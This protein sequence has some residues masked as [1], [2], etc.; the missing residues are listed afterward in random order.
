MRPHREDDK[1]NRP[2]ADRRNASGHRRPAPLSDQGREMA[3]LQATAGNAAVVQLLRGHGDVPVQRVPAAAPTTPVTG[4]PRA[5]PFQMHEFHLALRHSLAQDYIRRNV[6]S[7]GNWVK[8]ADHSAVFHHM[9][10]TGRLW[11]HRPQPGNPQGEA[12][13]ASM[14]DTNI[15]SMRNE[16]GSDEGWQST[17]RGKLEAALATRML[18]HYTSQEKVQGMLG[19]SGS[20]ALKSRKHLLAEDPSFTGDHAMDFDKQ[21]LA[22]DAFVFFFID[23]KNAPFRDTRFVEDKRRAARIALP[24]SHLAESGWI[25]LN[26]FKELEYPTLRSDDEGNLLSY[27]RDDYKGQVAQAPEEKLLFA[28]I[29]LRDIWDDFP[30]L[31]D[32]IEELAKLLSA[33][34]QGST[35]SLSPSD[36]QNIVGMAELRKEANEQFARAG[37]TDR[38]R[39]LSSEV[40]TQ[41]EKSMRFSN[42]V[43]RFD[44][45][46]NTSLRSTLKSGTTRYTTGGHHAEHR[47][48]EAADEVKRY[49][50]LLS[51]NIL[52]GSHV[53]PGLALRGVLEISRIERQGGNDALVR[54]LKSKSGDE[55]ADILLRDFIRPQAMLP[56]SVAVTRGD[57]QYPSR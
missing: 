19:Q 11:Q 35:D 18:H 36:V 16:V 26:D 2:P 4:V 48:A 12:Y 39:M 10:D 46:M 23:K 49:N 44:P 9:K 33:T 17:V 24:L 34:A 57:V 56:W 41:F 15:T 14:S 27:R 55:L 38:V 29:A 20:G 7:L 32:R 5:N 51:G 1:G 3:E 30:D 54:K 31:D 22:N 13:V 8:N 50:E 42:Q 43:R 21:D 6:P 47:H 40:T 45:H 37:L 28:R 25:M 52:A 53:I